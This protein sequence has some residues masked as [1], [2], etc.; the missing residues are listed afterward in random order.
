MIGT[1][2]TRS[3]QRPCNK[4]MSF[5]LESSRRMLWRSPAL[6]PG[7]PF[8]SPAPAAP[9]RAPAIRAGTDCETVPIP[10]QLSHLPQA[11]NRLLPNRRHS[12]PRD[13]PGRRRRPPGASEKGIHK[14]VQT[15][16]NPPTPGKTLLPEHRRVS[17]QSIENR[18]TR[19][20]P[21]RQPARSVIHYVAN[22]PTGQNTMG[23]LLVN[24]V[25]CGAEWHRG[26]KT[27]RWL[28]MQRSLTVST[29]ASRTMPEDRHS[30]AESSHARARLKQT[31]TPVR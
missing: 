5:L 9:R 10:P 3:I 1:A 30:H 7:R 24:P 16:K 22:P 27:I 11:E 4:P 31:H 23:I 12:V 17:P 19:I 8:A 21:R 2:P 6:P 25:S 18:Q 28:L 20:Q 15:M 14:N 26:K 29:G 13:R